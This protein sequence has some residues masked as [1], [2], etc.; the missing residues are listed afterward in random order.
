MANLT[1]LT[2][3]FPTKDSLFEMLAPFGKCH[4]EGAESDFRITVESGKCFF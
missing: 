3:K 2:Q 1:V 4:I